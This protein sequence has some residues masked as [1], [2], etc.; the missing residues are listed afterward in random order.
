MRT[1]IVCLCVFGGAILWLTASGYVI[2]Y[3]GVMSVM[4]GLIVWANGQVAR[5][6]RLRAADRESWRSRSTTADRYED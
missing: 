3:L 1:K 4:V 6:R 2:A 5:E